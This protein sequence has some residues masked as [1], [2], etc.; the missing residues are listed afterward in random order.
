MWGSWW[1]C[2]EAVADWRARYFPTEVVGGAGSLS[3]EE[4]GAY[5]LEDY[6][7]DGFGGTLD[8]SQC[9]DMMPPET[10]TAAM[11]T[12]GFDKGVCNVLYDVWKNQRRW[13]SWDGFTSPDP[14]GEVEAVPRE[15]HSDHLR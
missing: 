14:M 9:Y 1:A 4:T 2:S 12:M 8:Y 13:M 7:R 15:I 3:A 10:A 6:A 5:V 11:R